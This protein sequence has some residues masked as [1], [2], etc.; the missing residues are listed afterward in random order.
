VTASGAF[1][2]L[3]PGATNNKSCR[4]HEHRTAGAINGHRDHRVR[5]DASNVGGC[6]PNCQLVLP[7]QDVTVTGAVYVWPIRCSTRRA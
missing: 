1:N 2:L 4:W 5:V 6:A 7:S 3:D